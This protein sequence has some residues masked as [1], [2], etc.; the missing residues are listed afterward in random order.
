MKLLGYQIQIIQELYQSLTKVS[1][2]L[3][4]GPTRAGRRIVTSNF[5]ISTR[6]KNI[7]YWYIVHRNELVQQTVATLKVGGIEKE[8]GNIKAGIK[9]PSL[10][11]KK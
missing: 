3:L 7:K 1:K 5:I 8:S 10:G 2:C 9:R 6:T 4:I 11:T